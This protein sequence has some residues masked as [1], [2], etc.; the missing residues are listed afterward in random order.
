MIINKGDEGLILVILNTIDTHMN[1]L[2]A[3]F[4]IPAL[5]VQQR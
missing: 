3:P 2:Q 1:E 4:A 5:Q